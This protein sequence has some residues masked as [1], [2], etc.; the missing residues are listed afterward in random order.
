MSKKIFLWIGIVILLV[1]GVFVAKNKLADYSLNAAVACSPTELFSIICFAGILDS[2]NPCAFSVLLLTIG[3]LLSLEAIERKRILKIGG[4]F[5]VG[6]FVVY[7]LIGLGL[8]KA[9][10]IFGIPRF[11]SRF[12]AIALMIFG[13]LEIL[14]EIF[15]SFPI[16]L[17]IP[18]AA[19]PAIAK[20]IEKGSETAAILLGLLVGLTEFPCTGGPYLVVLSLLHDK[21]TFATGFKYLFV[22]NLIFIVPLLVILF[23]ASDKSLIQRIDV[24]R[25]TSAKKFKYISGISLIILG[26]VLFSL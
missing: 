13:L 3:F 18:G 25:K 22:Y 12:G 1:V 24:W 19:K 11:M 8:L 26:I 15:P 21:T 2:M 9:F 20:L 5:I 6:V 14:P 23:I 16:K 4:L 10:A 17:R 7:L